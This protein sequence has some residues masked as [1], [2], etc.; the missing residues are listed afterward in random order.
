M[1]SGLSK[2]RVQRMVGLSLSELKV[3]SAIPMAVVATGGTCSSPDNN[4][5]R[6]ATWWARAHK[7]AHAVKAEIERDSFIFQI[8]EIF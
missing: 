3:K 5:S 8:Y 2:V 7:P 4:A 6:A 1:P